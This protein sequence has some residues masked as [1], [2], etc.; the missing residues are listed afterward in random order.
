[1]RILM[2]S[3]YFDSHLGGI[4]IIAAQLFHGLTAAGCEI[5]WA[6]ADATPPPAATHS[7]RTYSMAV[8]NGMESAAGLPIPVVTPR[9]LWR[10]RQ[11]VAHAD[12]VLL[13]DCLYLSNLA[14][15]VFARVRGVPVICVQH[16]GF[17]PYKSP[18]LRALM[19]LA[20]L[21]VTRPM[22]SRAQQVVFYSELTRGYFDRISYRRPPL[23][24]FNGVDTDI[25]HP[26]RDRDTRAASR[27]RLA[28]PESATVVLFVGRF[29]EK[30]GL[31]VL[32]HM[33]AAAPDITWAFAGSGLMDPRKWGLPNV[34]VF[35][36]LCRTSLA[37][38][39]RVSD[40]LVLPSSGEGF[41]LVIQEGLAS[42]LPIICGTETLTAD[43][44]LKAFVQGVPV[45]SRDDEQTARAFLAAVYDQLRDLNPEKAAL[46]RHEF[47]ISRYSW[48][49]TVSR[50][51]EIASAL[52][53]S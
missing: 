34:R 17:V 37:E 8:W 23:L 32:R 44:A 41:P 33:A 15:F 45:N 42:G 39:Y 20:N 48:K 7:S 26:V 12:V 52:G 13:H 30:K 9:S 6:A 47:A 27:E 53:R 50:Y 35:S 40:A 5:V 2:V 43:E 36:G 51:R 24:L 31:G 3:H 49:R 28:L 10:L 25:F 38:L 18:F 4:E 1:M 16:I 14:A 11:E 22:L 46:L 19:R 29:V 21:V